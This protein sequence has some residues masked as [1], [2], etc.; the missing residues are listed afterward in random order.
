MRLTAPTGLA[1]VLMAIA[2][3]AVPA[4]RADDT[5]DLA[6]Q[7]LYHMLGAMLV[8]GAT[9]D[10]DDLP[11]YLKPDGGAFAEDGDLDIPTSIPAEKYSAWDALSNQGFSPE[12]GVTCFPKQELCFQT[13]GQLDM[14]WTDRIYTN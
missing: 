7:A 2:L 6:G 11:Y 10:D 12:E 4:A 8:E 9:N 5:R 3:F 1:M 14:K 13:T